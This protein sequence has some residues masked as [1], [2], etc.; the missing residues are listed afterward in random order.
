VDIV[1]RAKQA[2]EHLHGASWGG[3]RP[4]N[5]WKG[6]VPAT[7]PL[8]AQAISFASVTRTT[9][10]EEPSAARDDVL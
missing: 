1:G 8:G 9:S 6:L 4:G 5:F 2:A 7:I 10:I 3:I